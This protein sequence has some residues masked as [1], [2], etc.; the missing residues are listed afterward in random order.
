MVTPAAERKAVAHL[1]DAYGMSEWRACKQP[2]EGGSNN[3]KLMILDKAAINVG[4]DPAYANSSGTARSSITQVEGSANEIVLRTQQRMP[5]SD[6]VYREENTRRIADSR[7]RSIHSSNPHSSGLI[8]E[9]V[10]ATSPTL[11]TK[12]P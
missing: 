7:S 3:S 9:G 2:R 1:V 5:V 6:P 11:R 8:L 4:F 12:P 10:S